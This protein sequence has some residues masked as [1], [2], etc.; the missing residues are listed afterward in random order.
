MAIN[1]QHLRAFNMVAIEGSFTRAARRLNISQPTLSQHIKTL[2]GRYGQ[3]LF[4]ARRSPLRLTP[5]GTDLLALTRDMFSKSDEIENLLRDR[6]TGKTRLVRLAADSP[7]YA[8]RLTHAL[9]GSDPRTDIEVR[10]GNAQD[11]LNLLL[12]ARADIAIVSDPH[13]DSRLTYKP[14]FVDRLNVVVSRC[15]RLAGER[16]FPLSALATETLLIREP[17]SKTRAAT[18]T[19]LETLGI[20]PLRILPMHGREAIREAIAL[21]LGVSLFFSSECPPDARLATLS[22]DFQP[23]SALLT[24]YL[25]CRSEQARS[26]AMR[27]IYEAANSLS[28]ENS[29]SQAGGPITGKAS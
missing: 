3:K 19:L 25:V 18:E 11:T 2:E 14:M 10:I 4:E 22:P 24:G 20:S 16:V 15:H 23:N 17:T 21:G 29:V 5:I 1:H 7:T 27:K 8:A 28:P 26:S 6:A 9:I 13:I 12:D